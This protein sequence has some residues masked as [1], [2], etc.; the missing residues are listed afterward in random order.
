MARLCMLEGSVQELTL[1]CHHVDP[2]AQTQVVRHLYPLNHLFSP[3]LTNLKQYIIY[4]IYVE[5]N[6]T[7]THT[8][9]LRKWGVPGWS[10]THSVSLASS[11][12]I[13]GVQCHDHLKLTNFNLI[14]IG[15][16]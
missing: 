6:I 13:K 1:P 15:V 2:V 16:V 4:V 3:T 9:G 10:Q 5:R 14:D 12:E 11:P 8:H 7:H